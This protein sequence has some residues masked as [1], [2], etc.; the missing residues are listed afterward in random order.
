MKRIVFLLLLLLSIISLPAYSQVME[1]DFQRFYYDFENTKS[2]N[3]T[4]YEI[5][6]DGSPYLNDEFQSGKII[7]ADGNEYKDVLL[8]YNA[9]SDQFEFNRNNEILA[10][11]KNPQFSEFIFGD[12]IFCYQRFQI[13]NEK[14]E[15]Y[16]EKI[17]EGNY[18]LYCKHITILREGEETGAF[19]EAKKPTFIPQK[20]LYMIGS[21]DKGIVPIKGPKDLYNEFQDIEETIDNY[22]GKKKLK[23]KSEEDYIELINF[24]NSQSK[25]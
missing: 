2:I 18:S 14:Q 4:A 16:L 15:G 21:K 12:H 19:Q 1:I 5:N 20:P 9:Y 6:Y 8:R 23:L 11:I 7:L 17:R 10:I 13:K 25:K 3:K 24:L 22:T